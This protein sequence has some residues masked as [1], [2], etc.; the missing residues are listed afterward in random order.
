MNSQQYRS[1]VTK[2]L[3]REAPDVH[4]EI[5]LLY[6]A[7]PDVLEPDRGWH[8]WSTS[9][10]DYMIDRHGYNRQSANHLAEVVA[11]IAH[12]I[13]KEKHRAQHKEVWG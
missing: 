2:L 4:M 3:D 6:G 1:A 10:V 12:R 9:V 8:A 5:L 13:T 7:Q 11:V